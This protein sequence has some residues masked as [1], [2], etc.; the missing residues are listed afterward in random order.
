MSKRTVTPEQCERARKA[1]A[2]RQ[3]A[4]RDRKKLKSVSVTP[5]I[6]TLITQ[7]TPPVPT[8]S[9]QQQCNYAEAFAYGWDMDRVRAASDMTEAQAQ[10]YERQD[11]ERGT[12]N[13]PTV[14]V[15]QFNQT[16]HGLMEEA[17]AKR[18]CGL[19][20]TYERGLMARID[21]GDKEAFDRLNEFRR[22]REKPLTAP[23]EE[24]VESRLARLDHK[25]LDAIELKLERGQSLTADDRKVRR[26]MAAKIAESK[27]T[28]G[29]RAMVQRSLEKELQ[30][31][32][33]ESF[34]AAMVVLRTS[35]S[36]AERMDAARFIKE[37]AD[38]EEPPA[39]KF[40]V[41]EAQPRKIVPIESAVG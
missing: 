41:V 9:P 21:Q 11:I 29:T 19:D 35:K 7:T 2:F 38:N 14:E 5:Q 36:G 28:G 24:T 4:F 18:A 40:R 27:S 30:L 3:K 16:F 34:D 15:N 17:R 39:E 13:A 8:V 6:V 32:R 20:L 31:G 22:K 33:Q 37:W 23:V 26:D 12:A 25:D 10:E 1:N